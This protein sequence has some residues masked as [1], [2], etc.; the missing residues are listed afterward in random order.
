VCDNNKHIEFDDLYSGWHN[1]RYLKQC[2]YNLE[3][4]ADNGGLTEDEW[5]LII[6]YIKQ[7][8]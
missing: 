1:K 8:G 4:K 7:K 6:N 3:E 2:Y 5:K